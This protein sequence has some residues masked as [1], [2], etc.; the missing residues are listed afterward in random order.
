MIFL[1]NR[2]Y[3]K[4]DNTFTH[5]EG[6]KSIII[7]EREF[8]LPYIEDPE[9]LKSIGILGIYPT[10]EAVDAAYGSRE[11]FWMS[12]RN[13]K[14]KVI[15]IASAPVVAELLI[16]FW[17][18][19]FA[20]TS[21]ISLHGLYTLY[22]NNEN[23]GANCKYQRTNYEDERSAGDMFVEKLTLEQFSALYNAASAPVA[24]EKLP[25]EAIPFE[26]LLMSYMA[27]GS[28]FGLRNV[29]YKK[30]DRIVRENF[31][32]ELTSMRDDLFY[33]THNFYLLD[34]V[35]SEVLITD[36]IEVIR[37][38]PRLSWALDEVFY[39]GN[40]DDILAKYSLMQI[41]QFL[42]IHQKLIQWYAEDFKAI[43]LINEGKY[44]EFI[45]LDV[46]DH[47]ANYFCLTA[48]QAK[49]N[50]L[51]ISYVYQLK[52]LDMLEQL[53]AFALK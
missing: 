21:A 26:F 29:F 13:T 17:K 35:A 51:L 31:A 53:N 52:R 18:S 19:V 4:H 48:S 24:L 16:E 41:K 40:E 34:G 45:T 43:D 14:D 6:Q 23:S 30:V 39:F 3:L 1:F 50:G 32:A 28:N 42:Q 47:K 5:G 46:Y 37:N 27:G 2:I 25:K 20:I 11:G 33:Q 7:T 9:E 36:P 38:D 12:L 8:K 15:V 22:I 10:L 49:V 44:D